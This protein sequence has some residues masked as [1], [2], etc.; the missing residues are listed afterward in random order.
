MQSLNHNDLSSA[1]TADSEDGEDGVDGDDGR[2]D[3]DGDGVYC[4][5]GFPFVQR[6]RRCY[7]LIESRYIG[8]QQ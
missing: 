5:G 1:P 3:G 8:I 7:Q 4:D 2:G 6:H